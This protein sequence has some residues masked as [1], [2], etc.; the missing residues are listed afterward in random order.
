MFNL[1][2]CYR[3]LLVLF[4]REFADGDILSVWDAVLSAGALP[5]ESPSPP[6]DL[7]IDSN[8]GEGEAEL[9]DAMIRRA[10]QRSYERRLYVQAVCLAML[11]QRRAFLLDECR[12]FDDVLQHFNDDMAGEW[13]LRETLS[14]ADQFEQLLHTRKS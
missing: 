2:F 5:D 7:Q 12:R 10:K 13:P 14:L 8:A 1:Y 6:D 9:V 3:W 4:K 11:Q